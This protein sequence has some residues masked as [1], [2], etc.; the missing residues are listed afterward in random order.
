[1][2][3]FSYVVRWDHGFA[4]NPF[5]G[6][7]SLATCK[8]HI[9]LNA[10]LGD[11]VIG[12]GG[13]KRGLASRAIFLLRITEIITFDRYW[14]DPRF[15]DKRPLMNGSL[16]QRFGDNIYHRNSRGEWIQEDS[17][18]SWNDRANSANMKRDTG[19]TDRVLLS[20]D[21][22]YWGNRSVTIPAALKAVVIRRPGWK[23][24]E[25]AAE[26]KAAERWFEKVGG[27]GRVGDPVEWTYQKYWR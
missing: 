9:R 7:C 5:Y 12:T 21:F 24:L 4:P 16:E 20:D 10:E 19:R 26:L 6:V 14:D 1:M 11:L 17:R 8:P 25:T 3:C 27:Q 22:T 2:Q 18:H 23:E 13:A 15:R